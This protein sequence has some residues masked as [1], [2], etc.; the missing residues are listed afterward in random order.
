MNIQDAI[1]EAAQSTNYITRG[2]LPYTGLYVSAFLKTPLHITM[3][4]VKRGAWNPTPEELLATDW[5]VVQPP[6]IS[7]FTEEALAEAG[8]VPRWH[9]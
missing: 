7:D 6:C 5:K 1:R 4:G 3:M 2:I 9:P 8:I